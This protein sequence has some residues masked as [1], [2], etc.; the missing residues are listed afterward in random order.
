MHERAV[1]RDQIVEEISSSM[2]C[3]TIDRPPPLSMNTTSDAAV[4]VSSALR[5]AF[6]ARM[7]SAVGVGC[8]PRKYRKPRICRWTTN[9]TGLAIP[10]DEDSP[11]CCQG[12]GH[13]MSGNA[14]GDHQDARVGLQIVVLA[15]AQHAALA[16]HVTRKRSCNRGLGQRV[17]EDLA[18]GVAHCV[19]LRFAIGIKHGQVY[20]DSSRATC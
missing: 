15:D 1:G 20:K 10:P 9:R 11:T 7:D 4:C 17:A 12:F 8:P 18:S 2:G 13:R 19:E 3:S 5:M 16:V 14:D 6:A